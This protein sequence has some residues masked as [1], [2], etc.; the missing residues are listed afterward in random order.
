MKGFNTTEKPL[1]FKER[2]QLPNNKQLAT[3]R[4][5]KMEKNPK[6]RE[7]VMLKKQLPLQNASSDGY[8]QCSYIRIVVD[9]QVHCALVMGNARVH[10]ERDLSLS[11]FVASHVQKIRDSTDLRE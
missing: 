11:V 2:P 5:K 6:Y 7:T 10:Q 3:V 4:L 8:G 1:P 9:E